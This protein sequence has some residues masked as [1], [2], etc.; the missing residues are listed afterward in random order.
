ML[1]LL[2]KILLYITN[3]QEK[4]QDEEIFDV[5]FFIRVINFIGV[6]PYI[7]LLH[8][9]GTKSYTLVEKHPHILG[10]RQS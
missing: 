6:L 8:Y 1:K 4:S 3:N 2:K 5:V 9:V 10:E 7:T